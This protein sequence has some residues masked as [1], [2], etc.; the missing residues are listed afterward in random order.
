MVSPVCRIFLNIFTTVCY[1]KYTI[2]N[3]HSENLKTSVGSSKLVFLKK[4]KILVEL[5][6]SLFVLLWHIYGLAA[7]LDLASY[8]TKSPRKTLGQSLESR[9][10]LGCAFP[11]THANWKEYYALSAVQH[12]VIDIGQCLACCSPVTTFQGKHSGGQVFSW[13][14]GLKLLWRQIQQEDAKP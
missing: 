13:S 9:T 12:T 2:Y 10:R 8:A 14:L 7:W 6:L 11:F 3:F 4:N 1:R 5:K